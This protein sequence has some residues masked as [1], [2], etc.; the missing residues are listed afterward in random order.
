[1]ASVSDFL[2]DPFAEISYP[3][4]EYL[5]LRD[6]LIQ[7]FTH[8]RSTPEIANT[9][10]AR[11][12]E[13]EMVPIPR[14]LS[15]ELARTSLPGRFPG[16]GDFFA[17]SSA[18]V[19]G[20]FSELLDPLTQYARPEDVRAERVTGLEKLKNY[21]EIVALVR[22]LGQ[23]IESGNSREIA[24]LIADDYRDYAGRTAKKLK[25]D[26]A[27][28]FEASSDR[29][30]VPVHIEELNVV[31]NNIVALITGAWE[32]KF[33]GQSDTMSEFFK[34]ELVMTRDVK[35][36]LRIGSIKHE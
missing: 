7:Y 9:L 16:F 8:L 34:L 18:L 19:P 6:W 33:S 22:A 27:K 23:A 32:A 35:G 13:F 25:E 36:K 5:V 30:L 20:F 26:L 1:M 21:D 24:G 3:P 17:T 14:R 2:M 28:F 11:S 29:R 10:K 12:A 15:E 31:G 4:W